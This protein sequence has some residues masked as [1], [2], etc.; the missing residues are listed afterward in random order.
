[1]TTRVHLTQQGRVG[2]LT[3]ESDNGL[4]ILHRSTLEDLHRLLLQASAQPDWSALIVTGSGDRAFSAGADLHELAELNPTTALEF[5][6]LGQ[7]VTS[8]LADFPAPVIA[9]LNGLAYGGGLELAVACDFRIAATHARFSYPATKLGILP[10]F[11]GTQRAPALIGPSRTRELMYLGRTL[12][13]AAATA[14]GLVN[15]I[16]PDA[17]AEARAWAAELVTR[18]AYAIR[19]V[20]ETIGMT[21]RADFFF[22]QEAFANCFRQPGINARLKG[23]QEALQA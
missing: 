8:L 19:Q 22:E 1:M 10:G 5:S 14:W 12:D 18:D 21:E 13:A 9:A 2:I 16:A 11:G 20:K 7:R 3:L 17:L 15:A 6:H 4:Q 23:W